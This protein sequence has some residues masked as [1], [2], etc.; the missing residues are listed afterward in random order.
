MKCQFCARASTMFSAFIYVER[1]EDAVLKAKGEYYWTWH[2]ANV[3]D[4]DF[5]RVL[6][7]QRQRDLDDPT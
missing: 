6:N 1:K 7:A 5:Q 2:P 4:P 3:H